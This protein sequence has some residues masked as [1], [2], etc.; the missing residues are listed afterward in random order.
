MEE[1]R[2]ETETKEE[3]KKVRCNGEITNTQNIKR[4]VEQSTGHSTATIS[5]E[6]SSHKYH[7]GYG[8]QGSEV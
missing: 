6:E 4:K 5:K 8:L 1:E 2:E 7:K 3:P